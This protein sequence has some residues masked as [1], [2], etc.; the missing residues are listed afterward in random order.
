MAT[1]DYLE[2]SARSCGN[3]TVCCTLCYVPE[4]D[5]GE[6]KK[7]E[8]CGKGCTI[9]ESRPES[10]R[11][12]ECAWKKGELPDNM[13][14]D[15][16]GVMIEVYPLMVAVILAPGHTLQSISKNVLLVLDEYVKAGKPVIA[17]GQF[18][19]LPPGM[20]PQEAQDILVKTIKEYKYGAGK[21]H[22]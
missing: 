20:T 15:K 12:Y 9:Y 19:R 1:P 10:C 18:V 7:C 4:F 6:G 14:P 21:F 22:N 8:Y 13:R 17:T 3:C 5:K 16:C 2:V 11:K